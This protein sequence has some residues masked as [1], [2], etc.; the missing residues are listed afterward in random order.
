MTKVYVLTQGKFS[1]CHIIGIFS[2]SEVAEKVRAGATDTS[3]QVEERTLDAVAD[4]ELGT[5][6]HANIRL[7][8]GSAYQRYEE[9]RFRHPTETAILFYHDFTNVPL[10][11][12]VRSPISAEHAVKVAVEKRQ[13]WLRMKDFKEGGMTEAMKDELIRQEWL[14]NSRREG[15]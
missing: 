13:E 1:D 7:D 2:T 8:D 9:E 11:I 15:D 3:V 4:L 10:I 12:E 14:L 5:V 6:W